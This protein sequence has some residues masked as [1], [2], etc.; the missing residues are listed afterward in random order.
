M[1]VAAR[2]VWR[3]MV[4]LREGAVYQCGATMALLYPPSLTVPRLRREHAA[5]FDAASILC[6]LVVGIAAQLRHCICGWL[7]CS[8]SHQVSLVAVYDGVC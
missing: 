8:V 2:L 5:M 3:N 4:Y 1:L 6:M 7:H